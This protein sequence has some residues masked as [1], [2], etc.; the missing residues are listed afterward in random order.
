MLKLTT[1]ISL[2]FLVHSLQG[3]FIERH[4]LYLN[5][6]LNVGD[7]L[8]VNLGMT[9]VYQYKYAFQ[10]GYSAN[11]RKAKST[12]DNYSNNNI[13]KS[14]ITLG[15]SD[16][17]DRIEQVQALA[18]WMFILDEKGIVRLNL[19]AGIAYSQ[20]TKPVQWELDVSPGR[21]A[22]YSFQ[23][24]TFDTFSLIIQPKL[25]FTIFKFYGLSTGP[26]I[27]IN[28]DEVF[29]QLSMGSILG[30]VRPKIKKLDR[31]QF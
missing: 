10:L 8:G 24:N 11:S 19:S 26:H 17:S 21:Q 12:P 22:N 14:I 7:Y 16:P 25:E 13:F 1:I 23:E 6:D 30:A 4:A 5:T 3:Q 28:K 29:F 9:Y 20:I 31:S 2:F 18:G 15:L 27:Q